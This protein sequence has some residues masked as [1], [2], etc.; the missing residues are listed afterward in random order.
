MYVLFRLR[1]KLGHEE[2]AVLLFGKDNSQWSRGFIY[3]IKFVASTWGRALL[4]PAPWLRFLPTM[5]NAII[6]LGNELQNPENQI[7]WTNITCRLCGFID[8]SN[9]TSLR[10]GS[11][12]LEPGLDAS[13]RDNAHTIQRAFYQGRIYAHGIKYESVTLPNGMTAFL[14]GPYS[15]RQQ[16]RYGLGLADGSGD[17]CSKRK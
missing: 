1:K 2:A 13:R 5:N 8:C 9:F 14:N 7:E 6:G 16:D 15:A 12:P 11:G 10:P 4:N 3:M 17:Q